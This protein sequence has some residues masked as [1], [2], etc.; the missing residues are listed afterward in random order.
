MALPA[1]K[2]QQIKYT[3][4]VAG[5]QITV[6]AE[7]DKLYNTCTGINLALTTDNAQFSTLQLGINGQEVFPEL[8]EIFRI[9]FR[10]NA[11]FGYD[12]HRLNVTAGG[13]KISGKYT[14]DGNAI[15]YPYTLIFSLRLENITP[16]ETKDTGKVD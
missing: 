11:P 4:T 14:D 7:T 5:Q 16:A 10:K 1:I 9:L 2:Y 8:F 12:Y 13:S 6:D 3:V 15:A